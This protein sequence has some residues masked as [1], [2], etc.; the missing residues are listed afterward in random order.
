MYAEEIPYKI[1]DIDDLPREEK[2]ENWGIAFGL[3]AV[4]GLRPSGYMRGLAEENISGGKTHA[5]VSDEVKKYYSEGKGSIAEREADIAS[6]RIKFIL[7][8]KGFSFRPCALQEI[9]RTIFAGL[10]NPEMPGFSEFITH[11]IPVG[12]Y[13]DYPVT[14]QERVLGGA[15]VDY[16]PP[17]EIEAA[18]E[19]DFER[20]E[21]FDFA[22][23]AADEKAYHIMRFISGIWQIHPFGDGNTRACVTF[24]V[25]YL[26][27]LG[28]TVDNGPFE[29]NSRFFRDALVMDNYRKNRNPEYLKMFTENLLLD[30]NND[31]SFEIP[32]IS[33]IY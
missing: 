8:E 31:L 29:R 9:H 7:S 6:E 20:E 16:A 12:S 2:R 10:L 21:R 17:G 11:E 23:L 13:R 27:S 22:G 14:K 30:G 18:L 24:G 15:T 25:K 32:A 28:F 4:D 26:R 33:L 3:Q 1:E 19:H 5:Q